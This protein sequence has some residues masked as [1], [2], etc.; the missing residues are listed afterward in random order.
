MYGL[1]RDFVRNGGAFMILEKTDGLRMEEL[2]RVQIGMLFSN[3]IP[4]FLSVHTREID[5]NVTLQYDISGYKMLS[6]ILKS[7]QIGLPVLYH[8]LFQLADTLVEC[9]Q[10]MLEPKNVWIQ[11]D[12]I[13][14][15]GSVEQGELGLVYVPLMNAKQKE[16]TP[17]LF[18]DLV[19]RLMAYVQELQGEGIQRVLQLCDDERWD[20]QQLRELL[21]ELCADHLVR[22]RDI[23]QLE[24]KNEVNLNYNKPDTELSEVQ[25]RQQQHFMQPDLDVEDIH[26][27]PNSFLNRRTTGQPSVVNSLRIHQTQNPTHIESSSP[28]FVPTE[29]QENVE[30]EERS[31]PP[32]SSRTTYIWLICMLSM[33]LVWRF[34]YMEQP[35]QNG[36]ILS[37]SLSLGFIAVASWMWKKTGNCRNKSG[38]HHLNFLSLSVPGRKKD[39]G[40]QAEDEMYQ[41]SW[42]W[43]AVDQSKKEKDSSLDVLP[44]ESA[45]EERIPSRPDLPESLYTNEQREES[46]ITSGLHFT[47]PAVE[48]TVNLQQLAPSATESKSSNVPS[49]YLER[50]LNKGERSERVDVKGASFVIGRAT[51]MVQYVDRS[52]GVS[53]AHVELSRSQ[54]GYVI[55]DLGSVNGTILQGNLLAPYKEYPLTDGDTFILAESV[56]VYRMAG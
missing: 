48:A 56:Y 53:R 4:R 28:L 39:K 9:R 14:I 1:T 27:R 33:A 10:Y 20:I 35:G 8:L 19:I 36:L 50:T 18:R 43:N 42:R 30:I 6:Q 26:L 15:Q 7:G 22:P 24:K 40:L 31:S 34:I 25:L 51:D 13:F 12:Y 5:Q 3:R 23:Q 38:I 55:K 21:L 44:A 11:E 37:V 29:Q 32:N 17:R 2:S 52:T 16:H 41:E 46:V 47:T 49:Y 45:Y 54:S